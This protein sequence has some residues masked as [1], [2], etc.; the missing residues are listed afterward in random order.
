MFL[1]VLNYLSW[2]LYILSGLSPRIQAVT[3]STKVRT[4]TSPQ[5]RAES[6]LPGAPQYPWFPPC[7]LLELQGC[8]IIVHRT[9]PYPWFPACTLPVLQ[10]G[11]ISVHWTPQYPWFPYCT[12]PVL[13]GCWISIYWTPQHPWFPPF[14]HDRLMSI[15]TDRSI[16]IVI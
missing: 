12:L 9:P 4:A 1:L 11:W 14:G 16:W 13:P 8:W 3:I 10:R 6:Y 5:Y 15:L 7:I 2:L